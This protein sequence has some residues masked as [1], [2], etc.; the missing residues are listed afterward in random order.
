MKNLLKLT[1]SQLRS[2]TQRNFSLS[3][4]AEAS[5]LTITFSAEETELVQTADSNLIHRTLLMF[6]KSNFLKFIIPSLAI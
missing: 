3:L 1:A 4:K 5:T 2:T 6:V